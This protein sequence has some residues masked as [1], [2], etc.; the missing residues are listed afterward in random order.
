MNNKL[1]SIQLPIKTVDDIVLTRRKAREVAIK[2]G[3]GLADQT[4]LASAVSELARNVIQ[5]AQQGECEI[6]DQ[7]T[8]EIVILQVLIF[9]YGPGIADLEAA[10][11]DGF[12]TSQGLG[13]GLPGCR[14]LMDE[15]YIESG[16]QQGTK[17]RIQ[18]HAS[19]L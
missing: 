1:K 2:M 10:L 7:S 19:S 6:S 4:R 16:L 14:R 8:P 13:A 18:I 5:Y 3:F 17:I 9:D 11:R 12:S 15:F